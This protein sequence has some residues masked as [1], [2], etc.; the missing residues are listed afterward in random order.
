[1]QIDFRRQ[2]LTSL[3]SRSSLKGLKCF[4]S[5]WVVDLHFKHVVA[6]LLTRF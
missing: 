2:N 4:A 1:M 3:E 5:D 6:V